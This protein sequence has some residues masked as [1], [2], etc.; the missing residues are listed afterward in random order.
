MRLDFASQ[1]AYGCSRRFHH[2]GTDLFTPGMGDPLRSAAQFPA[3][4]YLLETLYLTQLRPRVKHYYKFCKGEFPIWHEAGRVSKSSS[5]NRSCRNGDKSGNDSRRNKS[6]ATENARAC[7]FRG[8]VSA[9]NWKPRRIP[10]IVK[11]WPTV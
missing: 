2:L 6:S 5:S 9:A 7:C 8:P 11:C 4:A 10:C 3:S 1:M